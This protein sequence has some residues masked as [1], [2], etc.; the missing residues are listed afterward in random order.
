VD[1]STRCL[2][3]L[4][5]SKRSAEG[6]SG[7]SAA[8]S[9]S[10]RVAGGGCENSAER[11]LISSDS[12][13]GTS[14][15]ELPI[16]GKH[17]NKKGSTGGHQPSIKQLDPGSVLNTRY[18]IVR[19]IGGGGMGAVIWQGSKPGRRSTCCER[20]G[21][22]NLIQRNTKKRLEISNENHCCSPPWNILDSDY[23]RFISTMNHSGVFIW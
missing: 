1:R 15:G 23:L 16:Q 22:G 3:P 7:A 12:I 4:G 2:E 14:T 9:R 20:D 21:E 13:G 18:E 10:I 6:S 8:P 5:A 11:D 19:R 17:H